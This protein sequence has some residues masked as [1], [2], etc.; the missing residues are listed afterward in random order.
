MVNLSAVAV[1]QQRG[2]FLDSIAEVAKDCNWTD[3]QIQELIDYLHKEI[4]SIDNLLY[5]ILE[6]TG[7]K[8]QAFGAWEHR[9]EELRHW[10]SL[11]LGIKIKYV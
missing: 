10:L 5:R 7:N 4:I 6:E 11:V 9:M 1:L 2:E 3:E 8:T